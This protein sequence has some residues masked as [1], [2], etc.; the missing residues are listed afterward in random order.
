MKKKK[1][2]INHDFSRFKVGSYLNQAWTNF[3]L[4]LLLLGFEVGRGVVRGHG[5]KEGTRGEDAWLKLTRGLSPPDK[6]VT[7]FTWGFG[8]PKA[9]T[10]GCVAKCRFLGHPKIQPTEERV[11][12]FL[13]EMLGNLSWSYWSRHRPCP[14]HCASWIRF[15][16]EKEKKEGDE[17]VK[18]PSPEE[19]NLWT[20][21]TL[22]KGDF[23]L[24]GCVH[25]EPKYP[26]ASLTSSINQLLSQTTS[27]PRNHEAKSAASFLFFC[28]DWTRLFQHLACS[29]AGI[30]QDTWS[31]VIDMEDFWTPVDGVGSKL[32]ALQNKFFEN[33]WWYPPDSLQNPLINGN[34]KGRENVNFFTIDHV[35]K[36]PN[37]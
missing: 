26:S 22:I 35:W 19:W 32:C 36:Y 30:S 13:Q 34:A 37:G 5:R 23:F 16:G 25:F 24:K 29:N 27:P 10:L 7:D 17:E 14:M 3:R 21:E 6:K 31:V 12:E 11:P 18:E 9:T 2:Y 4:R 15:W 33:E 1:I 28:Q 8:L 20:L